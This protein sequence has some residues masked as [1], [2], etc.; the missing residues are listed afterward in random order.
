MLL[1][2]LTNNIQRPVLKEFGVPAWLAIDQL[3]GASPAGEFSDMS[4]MSQ[5]YGGLSMKPQFK[6][7]AADLAREFQQRLATEGPTPEIMN[8]Y[9]GAT[10]RDLLADHPGLKA[11]TKSISQP[12]SSNIKPRPNGGH[13]RRNWDKRHG[14]THNPDGTPKVATQPDTTTKVEP[15]AGPNTQPRDGGNPGGVTTS[16]GNTTVAPTGTDTAP[17]VTTVAPNQPGSNTTGGGTAPI[18]A[19]ATKPKISTAPKLTQPAVKDPTTMIPQVGNVVK[20]GSE[21]ELAKELSKPNWASNLGDT[22]SKHTGMS[23]GDI[24]KFASRVGKYAIPAGI[25]LALLY[26][27]SKLVGAMSGKKKKKL[28]AMGDRNAMAKMMGATALP[29]KGGGDFIKSPTMPDVDSGVTSKI[30]SKSPK[31]TA[32]KPPSSP[33]ETATAGATSA[34]NIASVANPKQAYGHRR[35]DGKGIPKAPQKMNPD[36]TAKNALDISTNLMGGEAIKR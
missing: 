11:I 22:L 34:G 6:D 1:R 13:A 32:Y 14:K 10:G 29:G 23:G 31:G 9:K 28:K 2:E 15:N 4:P 25:V 12:T 3:F 24:S 17:K 7:Q 8:M 35:R 18:I 21:M 26:G 16:T 19:P 36:G 30:M 20:Q 5:F 27:G 33:M